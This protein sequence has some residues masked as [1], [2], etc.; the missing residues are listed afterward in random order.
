MKN[1]KNLGK[2]LSKIEQQNITG[3]LSPWPQPLP[4]EC[5]SGT[6]PQGAPLPGAPGPCCEATGGYWNG[7]YCTY[8]RP[9]NAIT[10][11]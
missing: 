7:K 2:Q 4:D 8:E 11:A 10:D 3:G 1:L 5:Y 6:S 9:P